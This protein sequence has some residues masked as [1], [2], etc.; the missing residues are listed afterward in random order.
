MKVRKSK[1]ESINWGSPGVLSGLAPP[2]AQGVTLETRESHDGLPA[3]SLLLPL[4][5][6]LPLSLSL[7]LS[8]MI[9]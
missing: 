5:V 3:W 6:S 9:E 2:S 8:L 4:P 1:A 7:S